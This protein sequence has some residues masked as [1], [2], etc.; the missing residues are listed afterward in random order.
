LETTVNISAAGAAVGTKVDIQTIDGREV[1]L[2]IPA[3]IQY[4]TALKI[5]GEG[6]KRRGRPGDLLVRVKVEIPKNLNDEEKQLY[7]RLLEIESGK[8]PS[9]GKKGFFKDVF[10]GRNDKKK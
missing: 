10:G 5:A 9:S 2:K 7:G 6:V 1:E 8:K 4:G 3:G